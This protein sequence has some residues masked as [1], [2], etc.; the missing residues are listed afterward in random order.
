M[1]VKQNELIQFCVLTGWMHELTPRHSKQV[2]QEVLQCVVQRELS[3][4]GRIRVL[5]ACRVSFLVMY[6]LEIKLM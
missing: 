6:N 3:M 2:H 1:H 4:Q 5:H